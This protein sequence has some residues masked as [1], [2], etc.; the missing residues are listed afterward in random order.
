M[1]GKKQI[2]SAVSAQDPLKQK[3]LS[4]TDSRRKILQLFMQQKGA[5]SHGDIEKKQAPLLIGL[6]SIVRFK[7]F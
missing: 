5:L 6:P 7:L 1:A 2:E 4:V 3:G